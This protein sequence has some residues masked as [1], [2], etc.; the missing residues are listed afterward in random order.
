M[1]QRTARIWSS[2][3]S[4]RAGRFLAMVSARRVGRDPP[5]LDVLDRLDRA[6]DEHDVIRAEIALHPVPDDI[7]DDARVEIGVGNRQRER[8]R[9]KGGDINL[10][11]RHLRR[12]CRGRRGQ[13]RRTSA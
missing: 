3:K 13:S 6:V 9:G 5:A 12:S 4:T 8:G 11:D 7:G 10:V 1:N 2:K